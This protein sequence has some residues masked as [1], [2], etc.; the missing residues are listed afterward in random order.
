M[1]VVKTYPEM[2]APKHTAAM[3]TANCPAVTDSLPLK[4]MELEGYCNEMAIRVKASFITLFFFVISAC[5]QTNASE[6]TYVH[7][8]RKKPARPIELKVLSKCDERWIR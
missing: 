5:V 6:I 2:K 4:F 3:A 8:N 7:G 1:R